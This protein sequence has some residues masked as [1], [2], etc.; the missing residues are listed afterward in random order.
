M[1]GESKANQYRALAEECERLAAEV[2]TENERDDLLRK[3]SGY[4]LLA[5]NEERLGGDANPKRPKP[6]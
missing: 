5:E 1:A 3:A 2:K 6:N 4:R